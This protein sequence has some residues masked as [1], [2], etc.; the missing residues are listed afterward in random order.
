MMNIIIASSP[1]REKVFAE[2]YSDDKGWGIVSQ[3]ESS[4]TLEIYPNPDLSPMKFKLN[5]VIHIL[6]QAKH[7]LGADTSKE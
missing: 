3:G 1:D 4:L 7:K 6:E 2:L 5:E